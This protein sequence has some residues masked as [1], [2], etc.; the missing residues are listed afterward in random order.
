MPNGP[1][2]TAIGDALARSK[3][4]GPP[5]ETL[6]QAAAN[7]LEDLHDQWR[8][9]IQAVA[10]ALR[11]VSSQ[12]FDRDEFLER[13]YG[14]APATKHRPPTS[15]PHDHPSRPDDPWRATPH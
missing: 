4:D 5:V 6:T 12:G 14:R 8:V 13:C 7:R 15:T 9:D 3:P 11:R 1:F 2:S 10:D